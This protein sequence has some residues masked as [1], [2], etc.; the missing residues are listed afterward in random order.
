MGQV[1]ALDEVELC[2][3]SGCSH[4]PPG[5]ELY[6]YAPGNPRV[7]SVSPSSG[8][9]AGG[10]KVTVGG[11]NLGCAI[12]V[13]FGNTAAK[14]FSRVPAALHCGET[15]AVD[16]TSPPG[17]AGKSVAVSVETVESYFTGDRARQDER[18]LRVQ[19]ARATERS[20][21]TDSQMRR[22]AF[23]LRLSRAIIATVALLAA[24]SLAGVA[25]AGAAT[26]K[27]N[28]TRDELA[29]HHGSCSLREAI[30]AVDS[31]GTKTACGSAGRGSNAIELPG[32]SYRLTIAPKGADGNPTGDL[33]VT[34]KGRLT[35]TGRGKSDTVIDAAGLGDRALSIAAAATVTLRQLTITG[36]YPSAAKNG[37]PGTHDASCGA[38]GAGGNGSGATSRGMGGGIYNR[39]KLT[40]DEVVVRGN[41]AGAGG[42]GGA[43]ATAGCAG[44]SGGAGGDG[45]G[46]YNQGRLAVVDSSVWANKAG[47]GGAGGGA[48]TGGAG[49]SGGPGGSG[50]GI[51]NRGDLSVL[52]SA[53][54]NDRA[55][56]AARQWGRWA[57][58]A[59]GAHRR[60]RRPRGLG[61]S[62]LQ[63]RRDAE[64]HQH[65][66][67]PQLRRRRRRRRSP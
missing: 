8:P 48:A 62:P 46:I 15:K 10:T 16:A 18:A 21:G 40:L 22:V 59:G 41:T 43:G 12:G 24:V 66:V 56:G 51:Y 65:H 7:T 60:R 13:F 25:A 6:A 67:R 34:G 35:I 49:G 19:V 20:P 61:W 33:N 2:T 42:A 4:H 52:L 31:P 9:R 54:Y 47:A 64:G 5:D 11:D 27:V 50:G 26:L 38:G 32:G 23:G 1:P 45:G 57:G 30:G 28:T 3:V 36:G 39:G 14:S 17:P 63:Y 37:S 44:G 29:N 58:G 53:I 55:G